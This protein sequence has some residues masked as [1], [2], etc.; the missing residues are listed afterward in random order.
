M[1]RNLHTLDTK[2]ETLEERFAFGEIDWEIFEKVGGKL[3]QEI[4]FAVSILFLL[5]T[6]TAFP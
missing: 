5:Q 1:E 4:G 3:K 6:S 2:L